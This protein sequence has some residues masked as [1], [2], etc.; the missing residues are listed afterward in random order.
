MIEREGWEKEEGARGR[1]WY[2]VP[3]SFIEEYLQSSQLDQNRSSLSLHNASQQ[4]I[5]PSQSE[6]QQ[7]SQV[8]SE[9]AVTF[10]N[11][12][13]MLIIGDKDSRI[14]ELKELLAE[15]ERLLED[16]RQ[17][18]ELSQN[19]VN[20]LEGEMSGKEE[21]IKQLQARL[22]EKDETIKAKDETIGAKDQAINAA[23]AAVLLYEKQNSPAL[24]TNAP[25]QIEAKA[26]GWM[27]WKK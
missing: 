19:R 23:N 14:E 12:Q 7:P 25:K 2:Y 26:P 4:F 1:V 3:V 16:A 17:K 10:T 8:F 21:A 18:L 24:E 27:F 20:R 6:F 11:D 15:K 22:L 9:T 13:F 5:K